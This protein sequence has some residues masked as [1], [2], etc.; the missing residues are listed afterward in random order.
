MKKNLL[1]GITIII[2]L[3]ATSV[4]KSILATQ[5]TISETAN[6]KPNEILIGF[7]TDVATAPQIRATL[8]SVQG[9]VITYHKEEVESVNWDPAISRVRSFKSFP[10][11][12]HI[13]IP[14]GF[15]IERAISIIRSNP[16]VDFAE[17]N[18]LVYALTI[19]NDTHWSKLWGL[20]NT[21]QSGG[22]S[23][24]D[25]HAPEAW[26]I[27]TG[28]PNVIV[29]VIDTGIDYNHAEL[30]DNIWLNSGE[31]GSGKE[32]NGIDD[33]GN[34][35]EDDWHGWD[36]VSDDNDPMDDNSQNQSYHGT[37]VAGI[38]GAIGNNGAG[39]A[40]VT[41]DVQLMPLRVLDE[42]GTGST[43]D[44]IN[45]IDYATDN[46]AH[47]SNNS[48]GSSSY[49][50]SAFNAISQAQSAGTLFVAAAGNNSANNDST[51]F[52]PASYNL[53]IILSVLSTEDNDDLSGF[54]NYGHASVDIG[55]PG[56]ED[57]SQSNYNI[58]STNYSQ[59][60]Q[61]HAGTSMAA[62]YVTG[63]AA[64]ALGKC[65]Q[66]TY[67]QLKARILETADYVSYLSNKCVSDGRLNV[68]NLIYDSA[69]PNG[70]PDNLSG[71]WYSWKSTSL[72][73]GDNSS[74]EIGFDIQRQKPGESEYSSI[75]S[76][77]SNITAYTDASVAGGT[78]Y[79]RIR[80]Y[81]MAGYSSY[82]DT[83]SVTVPAGV[84]S[85][86]SDLTAQSP[87]AE[88]HVELSWQDNANNEE[89]F[90]VQRKPFGSGVWTNIGTVDTE[91]YLLHPTI[92][93]MDTSVHQGTYYY[94]VKGTNP[95][96]SS[97][98]SNQ[99]TVEVI[100]N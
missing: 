11:L 91:P 64:L 22:T 87:A 25:I 59:G 69:V 24:S 2:I 68:Y 27:S 51:P 76:V 9:N 79:Y 21:G 54:S 70:T 88:H 26:D 19:P 1:L 53:N 13:K 62:P 56:G 84:P 98:Y 46:G 66:M 29:A 73:W 32:T 77:D 100:G 75:Q 52:Y 20:Y 12:L 99:I 86:P 18:Y 8:D 40:G 36:F 34:G 65:P 16:I 71:T 45:A 44:I 78:I 92:S 23:R 74:N 14:A 10:Y 60:Y 5:D 35:Y 33:D 38:I 61:Y 39:V 6:Y 49:S 97:S 63:G 3:G 72:S 83:L 94:R 95:N 85:A 31:C 96:G 41:W 15:D 80:A 28:S 48:Y 57:G 50:Q 81:N 90:V 82:S 43:A 17:K 30:D 55:A 47:I 4:P 93:W 37:H 89:V 58:Y 67:S 7:K 42:E